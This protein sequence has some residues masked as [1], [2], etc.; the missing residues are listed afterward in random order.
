[1]RLSIVSLVAAGMLVGCATTSSPPTIQSGPAAEVTVD[2][3]HRVDNS[4]MEIGYMKPDVDLRGY[5][6]IMLDPVTVAYQRDPWR[7]YPCRA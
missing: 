7:D 5:T 4:V 2:G 6:A 3:L 1:M